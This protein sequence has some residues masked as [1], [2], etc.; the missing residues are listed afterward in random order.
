MDRHLTYKDDFET[1]K[2]IE[3]VATSSIT[4]SKSLSESEFS[5]AS[6]S[7][8]SDVSYSRFRLHIFKLLNK[9]KR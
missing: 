5:E 9:M 6:D 1:H 2:N 7:E 8:L 4:L 3:V